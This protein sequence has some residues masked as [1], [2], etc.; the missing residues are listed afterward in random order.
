MPQAGS[1]SS[2]P[3]CGVDLPG[4]EL[5]DRARGVVLAGVTGRLQVVEDLFVDIAEVLALGEVVEVDAIDLVDY[6][7]HQMAGLH[8][9]EGVFEHAVDHAPAIAGL[10]GH[11]QILERGKQLI[12][13]EGHQLVTGAALRV[14]RPVAPLQVLWNGRGVVV[15]QQLQFLVLIVDDL[16]KEQ[17]AQLADALGIA[18][19]AAVL[20]HEV[21]N[22]FDEGTYR[23]GSGGVRIEGGLHFVHGVFEASLA[24]ESAHE[25]HGGAQCIQRRDAEHA[26]IV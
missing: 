15:A 3:G 5:G 9:V 23:H 1:N 13:D 26:G 17:P 12:V 16:E 20:A 24:A 11:G 14:G 7:T 2:S 19:Y 4:H 6:L 18:V 21:L 25:L 22:G 10:V 8:V